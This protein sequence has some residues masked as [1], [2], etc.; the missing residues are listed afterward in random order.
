VILK[1]R[2]R[3]V[4]VAREMPLSSIHLENMLTLARIGVTILLLERRQII[5]HVSERH[6]LSPHR[7]GEAYPPIVDLVA[8]RVVREMPI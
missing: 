3:L 8:C 1:E 4:L 5:A 6:V 7:V 2:R